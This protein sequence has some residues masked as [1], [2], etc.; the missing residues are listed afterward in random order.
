MPDFQLDAEI[1]DRLFPFH[2]VID[3]QL[4]VRHAGPVVRRIIPRLSPGARFTNHFTVRRPLVPLEFDALARETETIVLLAAHD[5]AELTLK[6]QFFRL[7][8]GDTLAFF[9]SPWIT[10]L[11]ALQR[12]GLTVSD[13]AVHDSILDYLVVIQAQRTALDD[14]R[15]MARQ[16]GDARDTALKASRVK[17]EFLANMSHELRTPLNAVIG[18]AEMLALETLGPLPKQYGSY[19]DHI[20]ASGMMLLDLI[21]DLLEVSRIESGE[22]EL[23]EQDVALV[24]AMEECLK[25]VA[26]DVSRKRITMSFDPGPPGLTL[27]LDRRAF[28]QIFLNLLSNAVKFTPDGGSVKVAVLREPADVVITVADSGIGI[29]P[30]MIPKLFEPFRQEYG[31]TGLGLSIC[32]KLAELHGG[33]VML[34]SAPGAGTTAT[35]HLPASRI[36]KPA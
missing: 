30:E 28:K 12:L 32:R 10:S 2:L 36:V 4:T 21:N 16:L 25:I 13:F 33:Q 5:P 20:R 17:S 34:D 9:G 8:D 26:A 27:R 18:F 29:A 3:R 7:A 14:A 1:A 31:G 23:D 11:D 22:Y 24:P 15:K 35:L 6:G 19:A